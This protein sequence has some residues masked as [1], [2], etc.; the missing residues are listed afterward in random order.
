MVPN[1]NLNSA[2]GYDPASDKLYAFTHRFAN[3]DDGQ[4]AVIDRETGELSKV[5]DTRFVSATA[6]GADGQ[7][8]AIGLDG[9]LYKVSASGEFTLVG[10]TGYYPTRD[11]ETNCGAAIDFRTGQMYWTFFGFNDSTDRDYNRNGFTGLL[12]VDT[13]T[14][15]ASLSWTYPRLEYFSALAVQNAHPSAPDN[16]YDLAFT[17]LSK[18]SA[19]GQISFTIPSVTYAQH[20]LTGE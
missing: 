18:G 16:I 20:P 19:D 5:A 12:T 8:F 2:V 6:C 13:A 7:I 15:A 10:H 17:P 11:A 14:G 1:G 4:M 9:N 3:S